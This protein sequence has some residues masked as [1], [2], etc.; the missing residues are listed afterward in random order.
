MV[1]YSFL[2]SFPFRFWFIG[3]VF[4]QKILESIQLAG[5]ELLVLVDP[6]RY[7]IKLLKP[8]LAI[9]L[10]PASFD[11]DETAL[12]QDSDMTRNSRAADLKIFDHGIEIERSMRDQI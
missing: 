3:G 11:S 7:F 2:F 5:P 8:R 12:R 1:L 4:C 6:T 10:P 9:S